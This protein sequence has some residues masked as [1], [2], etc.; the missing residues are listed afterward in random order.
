LCISHSPKSKARKRVCDNGRK[1]RR[2]CEEGSRGGSETRR[3][4]SARVRAS[5]GASPSARR[6]RS[7][8]REGHGIHVDRAEEEGGA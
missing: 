2:G 6:D 8:A 7:G 4:T 3:F 5:R 1:G